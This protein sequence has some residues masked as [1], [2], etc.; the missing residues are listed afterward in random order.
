M[1]SALVLAGT[2][3]GGDPLAGAEGKPHKAL[4]EIEGR[5][6]LDRVVTALRGA[7]IERIGVSCDEGPVADL[8]RTL[9]CEVLPT[10]TG[11]SESASI[12]FA[13]LGAPIVIT[14]A[15]HALLQAAWVTELVTNTP[16]D[17]D[18]GVALA[19]QEDIEAAVPGSKRTYLRFADGAWSGCNLFYLRTPRAQAA[20]ATW[21]SVEADRKRPWRIAGRLGLGTLVSYAFGRLGLAQGIER[22]GKRIGIEARLVRASNGLAAVDVDKP[23][24]L[25]DIRA[26]LARTAT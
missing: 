19:R 10:G 25:Q 17:A 6:L 16:A 14:T 9:G 22:L 1:T 5:A 7:N 2:R 26:Y 8:A 3:P 4:I 20:L 13:S 18:L 23:Q 15:D 21:R 24:D 11:P 12:A